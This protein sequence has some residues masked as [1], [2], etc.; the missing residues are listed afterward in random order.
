[1]PHAPHISHSVAAAVPA[2]AAAVAARAA[3]VAA[4]AAAAPARAAAVP[5]R[6]AA[7]HASPGVPSP[8]VSTPQHRP[9]GLQR[10]RLQARREAH[11]TSRTAPP[12]AA[13]LGSA[14]SFLCSSS[15]EGAARHGTAAPAAATSPGP[16]D[17]N[18]T[19]CSSSAEGAVR[20]GTAAPAAATTPGPADADG[21]F[22]SLL[23]SSSE[24]AAQD[25]TAAFAVATAAGPEDANSTLQAVA[26]RRTTRSAPRPSQVEAVLPV[27]SR[28]QA[29][30]VVGGLQDTCA[31]AS[32]A[33]AEL[34]A[35]P[36]ELNAATVKL[37][38]APAE[39]N[40]APAEQIATAQ[41]AA[42][43]ARSPAL[44]TDV[45]SKQNDSP[46]RTARA[47]RTAHAAGMHAADG[48]S[49]AAHSATAPDAVATSAR[50]GLAKG[51][52]VLRLGA[53]G[54]TA[55]LLFA[56]TSAQIAVSHPLVRMVPEQQ[57]Q[58]RRR[59]A[60]GAAL[61]AK[62][63]VRSAHGRSFSTLLEEEEWSVK[64]AFQALHVRFPF[65]LFFVLFF[66]PSFSI[67]TS[68]C[69][70]ALRCCALTKRL[71]YQQWYGLLFGP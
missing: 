15:A 12:S 16:V 58:P 37:H 69:C 47:A 60:L 6:A 8:A 35:A 62:R 49:L 13:S 3:A 71:V 32:A 5:A 31:E 64:D 59:Q 50:A 57:Q 9:F 56:A 34:N 54:R 2:R 27:E 67:C 45:A 4:R 51:E 53:Q 25:A 17:A 20:H 10:A 18:G 40:A 55:H 42:H 61:K 70:S 7:P 46:Q 52:T 66:F 1:M 30:P 19:G 68:L 43:A 22:S 29:V 33:P 28:M 14:L 36:A 63:S 39:Q 41:H 23:V 11:T 21:T 48:R 24:G 26:P 38:A 65:C 44:D